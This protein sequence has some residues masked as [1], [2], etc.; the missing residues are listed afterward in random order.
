MKP[1]TA[2]PITIV[3]HELR[4]P[5]G[6]MATAA[7]SAAEDCTDAALR[8]RCEVIVRTAERMLR[9]AGHVMDIAQQTESQCSDRFDPAQIVRGTV[10]DLNQM[11]VPVSLTELSASGECLC[12]GNAAQL[13]ALVQ[14]LLTNASDHAEPGTSIDVVMCERFG[15]LRVEFVNQRASRSCHRGLGLGMYICQNLAGRLGADLL[16]EPRGEHFVSVLTLP[17]VRTRVPVTV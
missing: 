7:R 10:A 12:E 4:A 17:L 8:A 13:E 2:D 6:L 14:S 1:S 3:Y 9:I 5:L 11:N 16:C 15:R